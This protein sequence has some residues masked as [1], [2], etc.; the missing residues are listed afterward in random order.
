LW[1]KALTDRAHALGEDEFDA[2]YFDYLYKTSI[3]YKAEK[4]WSICLE[5]NLLRIGIKYCILH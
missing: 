2:Q 3:K 1:A 5:I 4:F